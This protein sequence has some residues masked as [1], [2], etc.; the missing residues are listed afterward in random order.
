MQKQNEARLR[1]LKAELRDVGETE[2]HLKQTVEYLAK[3]VDG[4]LQPPPPNNNQSTSTFQQ[5]SLRK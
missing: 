5:P 2:S 3:R 4:A 1:K